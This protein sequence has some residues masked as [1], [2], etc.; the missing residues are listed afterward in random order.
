M[1]KKVKQEGDI[2]NGMGERGSKY[3]TNRTS[4]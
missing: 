3:Q 4:I 2:W 1:G